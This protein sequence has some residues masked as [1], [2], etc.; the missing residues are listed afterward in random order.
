MSK[1]TDLAARLSEL[2]ITADEAAQIVKR[3]PA[4]VTSWV[5]G[6]AEP[7]GEGKILLRLFMDVDRTHAAQLAVERIRSRRALG[8]WYGE[9]WQT[10][11]VE[12]PSYGSGHS[13]ATGG[14][15]E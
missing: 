9:D 3:G 11:D 8:N 6:T 2:Q 1:A 4:E 14:Q 10:A 7:D 15:P 12:R 13:G 5:E